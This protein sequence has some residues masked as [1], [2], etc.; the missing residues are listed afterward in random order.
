MKRSEASSLLEQFLTANWLTTPIK[1]ENVAAHNWAAIG[2]PLLPDGEEDY[3]S[4]RI[5]HGYSK[6]ITCPATCIRYFGVIYLGVCVRDG[7]GT[8][9][10]EKIASDLLDLLEHKELS[11]ASG[12]LRT[13]NLTS[14]AKYKPIEGWFVVEPMLNFSFERYRTAP[15]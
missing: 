9:A 10:A 7:T 2:Q 15:W 12:M 3:I 13:W 8:R 5:D 11:D 4:I 14:T 6:T 1:Y